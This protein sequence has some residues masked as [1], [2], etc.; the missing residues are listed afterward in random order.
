MSNPGGTLHNLQVIC[1]QHGNLK[2]VKVLWYCGE[3]IISYVFSGADCLDRF[4]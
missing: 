3:G 1:F 2:L 4:N